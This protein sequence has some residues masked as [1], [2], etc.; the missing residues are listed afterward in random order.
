[1][2]FI[3]IIPARYN[4]SRFP[5][6]PLA[7]LAGKPMIQWVYESVS[8]VEEIDSVY[9]ATDDKRVY[10]TVHGFN[11]NAIM[12]SED[13]QCGSE[14]LAECAELLKLKDDDIIINVQGDEPL[15]QVET[16]QNLVDLFIN[17][18]IYMATLKKRID[19][20]EELENPNVVK[21]VTNLD[22]YA[23][24]FSRQPIPY[25]R[26]DKNILDYYKHVGIYGY[27]KDFLM[28]YCTMEQ[29]PLE[30]AESLEQLR[31]LENG[32]QIKVAETNGQ[33][34]GVD[35]PEQLK[36]VEKIL[37]TRGLTGGKE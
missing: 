4:S 9:V 2:K 36:Q 34:I 14:R 11:G 29:T 26:N 17:F 7:N 22:G 32:Y 5:G 3:S 35:T 16:I 10:D 30:K 8:Q 20:S 25:I 24:Y 13:H 33:T 1:M 6:K 37:F 12:T 21:V 28:R 18:D 31:V 19:S 15:V 27:K 23:L